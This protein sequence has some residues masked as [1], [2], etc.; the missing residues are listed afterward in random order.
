MTGALAH[1][2]WGSRFSG[3]ATLVGAFIS[4][5]LLQRGFAPANEWAFALLGLMSW[6]LL[7]ERAPLRTQ[8]VCLS[9]AFGLGWFTLGLQWTANSMTEHG[10]L[11]WL[12]AQAG[13][14]LLAL[15]LSLSPVMTALLLGVRAQ[16]SLCE[17]GL[18]WAF[19]FTLM[20]WL[21]GRAILNFD[22]LNPAYLAVNMPLG[23]WAPIGGEFAVLL[24]L[25]L[26]SAALLV[27]ML[28]RAREKLFALLLAALLWG[29][30][31]L[32]DKHEWSHMVGETYVEVM[33]PSLP[34]VD[35]FMRVDPKTRIE[36]VIEARSAGLIRTKT[37]PL[38]ALLPEGIINEP[39]DRLS[40]AT[41]AALAELLAQTRV[42]TF[43]NAFRREQGR[44][45]N[46]TFVLDEQGE[47]GQV[48]KRH[49]VPFGEFVPSG[50][51]WFI[52]LLGIPMAD[53]TPGSPEQA[54]L[55]IQGTAVGLLICYE[56]LFSDT[57]RGY[58]HT[59]RAP[60]LVALTAN[61]GW[62]GEAVNAQH[63]QMSRLRA[64]E[65]ARPIVAA[66][67]NGLSAV[68]RPDGTLS[69]VFDE[70]GALYAVV[71][72]PLAEGQP[73]P[74]VRVGTLPL[75]VLCAAIALIL[76]GFRKFSCQTRLSESGQGVL[77]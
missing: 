73:T 26:F 47:L 64:K 56:N 57:L 59:G 38:F 66:S 16:R 54:T 48:D 74:F 65:V 58:W 5:M 35:A 2:S 27:L 75:I 9:L 46:T 17:Y 76:L 11:P 42:P 63:L 44:F 19:L 6:L 31:T 71:S 30:G 60:T 49:L 8:M 29:G 55:D 36:A 50:A 1:K 7:L 37:P 10:H 70:R 45:Y 22:W 51:R 39:V 20:E 69:Q 41:R 15:L 13:V 67:N 52:N 3:V 4:G 21:R 23:G 32:A 68:I 24:A 62:F 53:L 33:Q 34:V 61:L 40:L 12:V 25:V 18:L 77:K 43:V 28:G 72:V 14:V